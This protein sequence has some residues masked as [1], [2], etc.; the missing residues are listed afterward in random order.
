MCSSHREMRSLRI[1]IWAT[2]GAAILYRSGLSR[3]RQ[4]FKCFKKQAYSSIMSVQ[5]DMFRCFQNFE[6]GKQAFGE[7]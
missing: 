4:N 1:R 7:I 2:S 3:Y 5:Q 6:G